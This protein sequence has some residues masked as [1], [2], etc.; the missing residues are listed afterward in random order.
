MVW[1]LIRN[2]HLN[3]L[4]DLW[5][6]CAIVWPAHIRLWDHSVI[7]HALIHMVCCVSGL[8]NT[9]LG[10]YSCCFVVTRTNIGLI[11]FD[12]RHTLCEAEVCL[13]CGLTQD[14][15]SRLTLKP[16]IKLQYIPPS[17]TEFYTVCLRFIYSFASATSP[18]LMKQAYSL[19]PEIAKLKN[20]FT[21]ACHQ[22]RG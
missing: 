14:S 19:L 10:S 15:H 2:T 7:Q 13:W 12:E 5:S 8:S 1:F 20:P 3:L 4:C 17:F 22:S 21:R 6:H 16:V 9:H 18:S 11:W